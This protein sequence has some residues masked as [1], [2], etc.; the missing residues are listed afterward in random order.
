MRFS[1]VISS[2]AMKTNFARRI[3]LSVLVGLAVA[4]TA[5]G[6]VVGRVHAMNQATV[7]IE[8]TGGPVIYIDPFQVTTSPA[9]ADFILITHNHTDHQS[10]ADINRVRKASTV[11]VSSP[12][13]IPALQQAVNGATIHAVT[14]GA[15]L[16]LGGVEI[17]TVPMYNVSRTNHPRAM[18]FVGY[19]VNVGG[20]RVY[21]GGDTERIP[22]MQTFTADVAMLP[23]GQRFTMTS[24]QQAVEAT[25]D[26]RPRVAIPIH[27]GGAEGTLAD[28][29][30]YAAAL[31]DRM[32][33]VL[34]TGASGFALEVSETVTIAE[35]P[36]S[37]TVI[38]G[39][40]VTLRVQASGSGT[41]SYQWRRNGV[42]IPGATTSTYSISRVGDDTTG[43]YTVVVTDANGPALSRMARVTAANP[44]EGKL[45]NLSVRASARGASAPL[46]VGCVVADGTKPV[47]VRGIGPALT[48]FGVA[49]AMVDPRLDVYANVSGRDTVVATNNDWG[50]SAAPTAAGSVATL[51]STFT[52]SGAFDLSDAG[53]RDA[54]LVA[55]V[56]GARTLHVYDAADRTGVA[57]VEVYDTNPAAPGRLVNLSARTF[58]GT[59]EGTIIVG[60]GIGGNVPKRLLIRGVGPTLSAFGVAGALSDPRLDLFLTEPG[61][62]STLFASN[63][64]WAEGGVATARAAFES[65]GAFNFPNTAS[66]DAVLVVTVPAGSYTAQISGV[67]GVTGEALVEIYELP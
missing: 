18:N 35:P 16:M 57:L 10:V 42:A 41:L 52:A 5:L 7:K 66:R 33:V 50:V 38:P 65:R 43:D 20:V 1:P 32:Q 60:F 62:R 4:S 61:G 15:R 49:G 27:W 31:R 12:P 44:I 53:S 59:G 67:G 58:A 3:G 51:R 45:T 34:S 13:G 17:E 63:D 40:P 8:V 2:A 48:S 19:I 64:N 25:L 29:E 47:L 14:P 39:Q 28:A 22:E 6:R 30:A 55:A 46:I 54:A 9:D 26:V 37:Q 21:H 24:V 36:V 11:F 56:D 23:L